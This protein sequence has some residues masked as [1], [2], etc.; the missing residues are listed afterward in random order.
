MGG[1]L[2]IGVSIVG[3]PI[4]TAVLIRFL[5]AADAGFWFVAFSFINYLSMFD[6]GLSPTLTRHIAFINGY[7][8]GSISHAPDDLPKSVAQSDS[9]EQAISRPN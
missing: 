3:L 7:F 6:F 9:A 8:E 5:P 1:W 2:Q 4:Q